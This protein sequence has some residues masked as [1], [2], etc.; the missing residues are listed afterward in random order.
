MTETMP[1]AS[2]YRNDTEYLCSDCDLMYRVPYGDIIMCPRCKSKERNRPEPQY[3][4]EVCPMCNLR[5]PPEDRSC[6]EKCLPIQEGEAI[7]RAQVELLERG[8]K[9]LRESLVNLMKHAA[10]AHTENN[11][12]WVEGLAN[13][14]NES[15]KV[16]DCPNVFIVYRDIATGRAW[17]N[18]RKIP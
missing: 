17:I 1:H 12:E 11:R 15:A 4:T 2:L 18:T 16:L 6:C 9:A 10:N 7:A 14:L 8:G 3:V 13:L 5:T